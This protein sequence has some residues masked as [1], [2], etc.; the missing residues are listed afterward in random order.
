MRR[1]AIARRRARWLAVHNRDLRMLCTFVD[2]LRAMRA[3]APELDRV[4]P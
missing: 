1:G 4:P 2:L 3:V